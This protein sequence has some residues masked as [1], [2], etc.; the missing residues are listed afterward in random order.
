MSQ[1]SGVRLTEAQRIVLAHIAE[2]RVDMFSGRIN[3]LDI[4][5]L[6][7][8]YR[9]AAIHLGMIEPPLVDIDGDFLFV[10]DAGR[11]A[12]QGGEK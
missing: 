10:T 6:S 8:P 4:R 12:L 2:P 1:Q 7:E 9:Q 5:R 11:R 3:Q